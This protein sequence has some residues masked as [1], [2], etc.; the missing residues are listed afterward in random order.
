M[1]LPAIEL[2][3]LKQEQLHEFWPFLLR[4]LTDIK[5]S[6]VPNWI[7]EDMYSALRERQVACLIGRIDDQLI[8]FIIYSRQLRSFN[9][10]PE[11]F[12]WCYW[13]IPLREW[14]AEADVLQLGQKAWAFLVEVAEKQYNAEEITFV[15]TPSRARA[16]ERKWKL[17]PAWVTLTISTKL[18]PY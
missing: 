15:T 4:G 14:P 12:I 6:I 2:F 13:A 18:S 16:F 1:A 7:P 3:E 10:K 5:K 8:G 9:F 11:L 17:R